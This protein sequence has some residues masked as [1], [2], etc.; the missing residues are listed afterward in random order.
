VDDVFFHS[1]SNA[2]CAKATFLLEVLSPTVAHFHLHP[3]PMKVCQ[4]AGLRATALWVILLGDAQVR[5]AGLMFPPNFYS[6]ALEMVLTLARFSLDH[7]S[8]R[9]A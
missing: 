8:G 3:S 5:V 6:G 4:V 2:V 7:C 1:Q 9:R